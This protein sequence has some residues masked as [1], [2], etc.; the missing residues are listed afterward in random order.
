MFDS[1]SLDIYKGVLKSSKS[2][3]SISMTKHYNTD[4]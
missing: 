3:Q 4:S 2:D 1:N